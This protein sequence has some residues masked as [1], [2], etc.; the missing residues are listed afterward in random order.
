[1]EKRLLDLLAGGDGRETVRVKGTRC[2][3]RLLP[4]WEVLCARREAERLA[5]DEAERA[6]CGNACLLARALR[7][8]GRRLYPDGAALL[9][10]VSAEEI[11]ALSRQYDRLSRRETPGFGELDELKKA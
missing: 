5:A 10:N 6:L 4:A 11:A 1:M 7:R 2:E 3:L 8:R 9:R